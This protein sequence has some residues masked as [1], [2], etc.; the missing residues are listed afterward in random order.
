MLLGISIMIMPDSI[1][2]RFDDTVSEGG[3]Y[4]EST[5]GRFKYW[6]AAFQKAFE[7]PLGVGTGQVRRAMQEK[8]GIYVDPHNGFLYTFL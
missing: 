3:S 5:Q 1:V 4:D 8:I 2:T 6:N 7:N